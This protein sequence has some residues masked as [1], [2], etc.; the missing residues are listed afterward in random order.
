MEHLSRR[1]FLK[2]TAATFG[3]AAAATAA[4]GRAVAGRQGRRCARRQR[5]DHPDVLR[6]VLLALLGLRLPSATASCGSSRA[7][8]ATRRAAAGCARA[9]PA[10]SASYYDPDRLQK[11]LIR[12][13]ERGK[14][15]WTAVTWDE[16]FT[17]IAERMNK[18]K[19][20]HGPESV[21]M[22]NHGIGQFFIQHALKSWGAINFAGSSFAQCRGPARRRLRAD[23]RQ[24]PR[25][26]RARRHREHELP[27]ADRRAPR[28]EHAQHAGAG[29]RAG[30]RA[31]HPDHRRRP[32]LL[33][34]GEQGEVLAADPPGHRP[35]AAARVVQRAG[36]RRP[37]RPRV[38]R[39]ARPRLRQVRGR[40]Q[41][42]HAGVG[43]AGNGPRRRADPRD[44]ARARERPAGARWST[45]AAA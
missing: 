18:I 43:G 17:Y 35:G 28:R 16:A 19:A 25:L 24:R 8:R 33:G 22:F 21:A 31:P 42:Q 9:A 30:G 45:R 4:L 41:G 27:R 38:R 2:I 32:A 14:E 39:E 13:G 23:L 12:R 37:L 40:D 3:A 15:E 34:G 10:P 20:Q 5:H 29:V 7:T 44:G 6:N 11:P 36:H 26:A 1:R